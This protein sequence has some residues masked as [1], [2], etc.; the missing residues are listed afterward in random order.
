MENKEEPVIITCDGSFGIEMLKILELEPK[1]SFC[2][3]EITI[4]NF[5]GVFSKP[6]RACCD[7]ICCIVE[8]IPFGD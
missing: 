3:K 4:K 2:G 1:C 7:N 5:G 8:A 6:T